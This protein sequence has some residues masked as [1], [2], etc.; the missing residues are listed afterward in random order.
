MH[1][2]AIVTGLAAAALLLTPAAALAADP[3]P[4]LTI[5]PYRPSNRVVTHYEPAPKWDQQI[6]PQQL[7]PPR[8]RP[9]PCVCPDPLGP[10]L[11]PVYPQIADQGL[12]QHRH[13]NRR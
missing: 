8:P 11:D 9:W 12:E 13:A 7:L 4:D 1:R 2:T 10:L 3:P 6:L 5:A